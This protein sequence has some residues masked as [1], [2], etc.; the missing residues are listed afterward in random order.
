MCFI[1]FHIWQIYGLLA[2]NKCTNICV[3]PYVL[4]MFTFDINTT[5]MLVPL[6]NT[7]GITRLQSKQ[8]D[9]I[10]HIICSNSSIMWDHGVDLMIICW[11]LHVTSQP[12]SCIMEPNN[13]N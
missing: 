7:Y 12:N 2:G 13:E 1:G 9:L 5:P 8:P 4:N 10:M 6:W 3:L 11:G